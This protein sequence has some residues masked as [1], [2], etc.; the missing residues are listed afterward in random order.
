MIAHFVTRTVDDGLPAGDFK[1]INQ[2]ARYL[3]QCGHVQKLEIKS[4]NSCMYIR[5]DCLPEMKKDTVYK[6]RMTLNHPSYEIDGA[7]CECKAGKGPK[8]SCK[9]VGALCYAFA[10]FCSSGHIPGFLTC[11]E[12]LQEWNKPRARRVE[13]IPVSELT[14]RRLQILKKDS[15]GSSQSAANYDP[16]SISMRSVDPSL[17]ENLRVD[18]VNAK[19]HTSVF[20]QILVPLVSV[21]LHDHQYTTKSSI[22]SHEAE[23]TTTLVP[24]AMES[25]HETNSS[26]LTLVST[27]PE[28]RLSK[29]DIKKSLNV[30]IQERI[31]IE[32]NTRSQ[33]NSSDWFAA[34][35]RRITGSKCGRILCQ[36]ERTDALLTSVLYSKPMMVL[37]P[38]IKW[39]RENEKRACEA[40]VNFMRASGHS[41][42]ETSPCGFIVCTNAGWLGASPDAFVSDPTHTLSNGIVEFKCP[43]TKRNEHPLVACDDPNFYCTRV[44]NSICL[45][46]NH[47]YYHQVLLQLYVGM[48]MYSWCDFCIFTL[49]G[50]AVQKL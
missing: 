12:R 34:R 20:T 32:K 28:Q 41:G 33:S 11:T 9:H 26:E 46:K 42:L 15:L 49:K 40:Y 25:A 27:L 17:E 18:L 19:G 14:S 22:T 21:A 29:E 35:A 6:I 47:S 39:G 30:T 37:P 5:A 24:L 16:R 38:P 44:G 3:F 2:K 13:V 23:T 10:E 31:K 1:G 50:V 7:Q 8:A 45:N 48:D 4:S 36:K 43:Y